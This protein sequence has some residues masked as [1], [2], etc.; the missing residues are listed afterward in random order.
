MTN[1]KT[2]IKHFLQKINFFQNTLLINHLVSKFEYIT[3]KEYL[4]SCALNSKESG[5]SDTKYCDNEIIVSLTTF[6]KRLYEVYLTIES[7]MQQTYKPNRIVLWL[8]EEIKDNKLPLFLLNQIKRGLEVRY[9]KDTKSYKKLIPSL[10]AFPSATIITIDDDELYFYDL[11]ENIINEHKQYPRYILCTR[12][13]Y[14]KLKMN[15][16]PAKY[17]KWQKALNSCEISP[18]NFATGCGGVLYPANCFNEEV[19]K[20]EIFF[21]ICKYADDIWFKAMSLLNNVPVKKVFTHTKNSMDY[22]PNI[23]D[24]DSRLVRINIDNGMNDIQLKAVF[25]KYNL[26]EKL[27]KK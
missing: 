16:K 14:I 11:L 2:K 8:S 24:S 1:I 20:E 5:I 22:Y 23:Q 17:V 15:K 9:C 6:D 19:L 27:L 26:Y 21:D 13:H 4:S 25:D 10:K 18:L 12:M 3:R 7:I